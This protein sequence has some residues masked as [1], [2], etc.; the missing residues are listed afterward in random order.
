[1]RSTRLWSITKTS[2]YAYNT[3]IPK[4]CEAFVAI[5]IGLFDRK[6]DPADIVNKLCGYSFA[7]EFILVTML[8]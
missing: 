8:M 5:I 1:L 7:L 4:A 2:Q 6:G 3:I